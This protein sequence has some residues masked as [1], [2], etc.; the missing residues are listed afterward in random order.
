MLQVVRLPSFG[1]FLRSI[2]IFWTELGKFDKGVTLQNSRA[3]N[4]QVVSTMTCYLSVSVGLGLVK[5]FS[6]RHSNVS[7]LE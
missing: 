5:I 6:K 4:K 2:K 1:K 3:N 7:Y